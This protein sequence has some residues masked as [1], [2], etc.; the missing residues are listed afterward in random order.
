VKLKFVNPWNFILFIYFYLFIFTGRLEAETQREI[1]YEK[2][3]N[4]YT[5]KKIRKQQDANFDSV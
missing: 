3:K 4:K 5:I 1:Q 2:S